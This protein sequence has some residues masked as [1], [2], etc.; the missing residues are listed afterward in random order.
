[1]KET[2]KNKGMKNYESILK[3]ICNVEDLH[4][5]R[6]REWEGCLGVACV[7]S[8]M[9]GVSA[10][11]QALGK[12]LGVSPYNQSLGSA[13]S[14]LKANGIFESKRNVREDPYLKGEAVISPQPNYITPQHM[15]DLVWCQVAGIAGGFAGLRNVDGGRNKAR[16]NDQ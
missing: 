10:N 15:S 14:R 7:I 5:L 16:R 8:F 2:N 3:K 11:L 4:Y 12:H 13:F 1:M 6:G 9:E